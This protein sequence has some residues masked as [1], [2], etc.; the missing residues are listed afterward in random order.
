MSTQY[1][2]NTVSKYNY[3]VHFSIREWSLDKQTEWNSFFIHNVVNRT[4]I[5]IERLSD[6][7]NLDTIFNVSFRNEAARTAFIL[8]WL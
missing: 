6:P 8:K 2:N 1:L 7:F 5:L 3:A 4:D